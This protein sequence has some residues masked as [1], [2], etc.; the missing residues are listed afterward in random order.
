MTLAGSLTLL[1]GE[2]RGGGVVMVGG[3]GPADRNND[4]LFPPI[5]DHLARAGVAVLCY[6]K[7]GVGASSGDWRTATMDDLASDAATALDFLRAQ[8]AVY[9]DAAGLFG[10]SEGGWVVLRAARAADASYVITNGCPGVSPAVQDRYGLANA[11]RDDGI[12]ADDLEA[13]LAS[14]DALVEA[15]R[16][17]ADFAGV[18]LIET[19][20][21][22]LEQYLGEVDEATW[23]FLKR[24]QD[25]DP[26][27]DIDG[28][29]CPTLALFGSEDRLVPVAESIALISKA[30]CRPGRASKATLTVGLFP[31]AD[32]RARMPNG[33]G[34]APGYL[35]TV[36]E[37]IAGRIAAS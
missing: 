30:V 36:G 29:R 2:T 22:M 12:A 25:H 31:G 15:G 23:A 9:A 24:K 4:T 28:M 18:R 27:P 11:L 21:P 7:R 19:G 5:R 1:D 14:Y 3:S 34:F 17:D 16:R 26:I 8:R 32:H 35:Q 13:A 10:H 37:W 20:S 33:A 6:D